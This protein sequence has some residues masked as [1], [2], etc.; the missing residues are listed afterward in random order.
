M[1]IIMK[2]LILEIQHRFNPLHVYC[3]LMERGI[4]K[5][6]SIVFCRRYEIL[7]YKWLNSLM[8]ISISYLTYQREVKCYMRSI[9]ISLLLLKPR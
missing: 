1:E 6:I 9:L 7:I 3:R 8:H 2:R 4:N 5:K